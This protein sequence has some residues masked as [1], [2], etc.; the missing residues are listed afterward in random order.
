MVKT[1]NKMHTF[2][3]KHLTKCS[4]EGDGWGDYGYEVGMI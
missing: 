3:Q 2:Y 4:F 1:F